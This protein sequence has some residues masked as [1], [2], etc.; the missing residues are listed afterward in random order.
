MEYLKNF[1]FI[2]ILFIKL[3]HGLEINMKLN[4]K[5]AVKERERES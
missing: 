1:F 3:A 4:S 5:T 2:Y